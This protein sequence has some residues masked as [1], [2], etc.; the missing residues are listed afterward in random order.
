VTAPGFDRAELVARFEENFGLDFRSGVER[1]FAEQEA[2]HIEAL[3][4]EAVNAERKRCTDLLTLP[5]LAALRCIPDGEIRNGCV[6]HDGGQVRERLRRAY[7]AVRDGAPAP[8]ESGPKTAM[9][10][11]GPAGHAVSP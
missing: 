5:G 10:R 11:P 3:V 6:V 1:A 9:P 2:D 4:V 7:L 8:D